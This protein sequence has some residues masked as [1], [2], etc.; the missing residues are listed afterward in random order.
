MRENLLKIM[1]YKRKHKTNKQVIVNKKNLK[2]KTNFVCLLKTN[3]KF[4]FILSPVFFLL[5]GYK[6][7]NNNLLSRDYLAFSVHGLNEI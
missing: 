6:I 5:S 1:W 4:F 3:Y 7:L 2:I